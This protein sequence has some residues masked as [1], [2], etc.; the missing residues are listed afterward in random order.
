MTMTDEP[1]LEIKARIDSLTVS[2]A[3]VTKG[4]HPEVIFS[5]LMSALA[6]FLAHIENVD[7]ALGDLQ[8]G[9]PELESLTRRIRAKL[10]SGEEDEFYM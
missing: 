5:S 7:A 8:D 6:N 4:E 3:D 10:D 1:T 9:L 2:I